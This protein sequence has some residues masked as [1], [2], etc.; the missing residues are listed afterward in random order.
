MCRQ[1]LR[2]LTKLW[3]IKEINNAD[4]FFFLNKYRKM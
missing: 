2:A 1:I 4:N 3:G